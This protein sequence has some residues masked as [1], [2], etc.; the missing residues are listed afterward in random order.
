MRIQTIVIILVT[1]LLTIILMQNTGSVPFT[2]LFAHLY[3]SKLVMLI[4]VS[5]I[6]F[7]LGILVGRPK[8]VRRLGD[9]FPNGDLEK[10]DPNTLS[11]EDKDYIS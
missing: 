10:E 7:V 11:D 4:L 6:A 9:D 8:R 2:L 5:V 3:I 1:F